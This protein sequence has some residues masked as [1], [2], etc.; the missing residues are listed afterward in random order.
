[1]LREAPVIITRLTSPVIGRAGDRIRCDYRTAK[2]DGTLR[3]IDGDVWANEGPIELHRDGTAPR[4]RVIGVVLINDPNLVLFT[5]TNRVYDLPIGTVYH[6]DGRR[7]HG[8]LC[9][10]DQEKGMFGFLAWDVPG[11]TQ[12]QSLLDDLLPSLWAFANRQKR[13][14]ILPPPH[15]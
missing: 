11:T 8:A 4:H 12:V 1:M 13:V 9:R 2:F 5:K 10:N 6:I 3:R 7:T 14:N 15:A